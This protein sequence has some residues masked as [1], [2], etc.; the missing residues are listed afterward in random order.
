MGMF[1]PDKEHK[2]RMV[3]EVDGPL[4]QEDY[5]QYKNEMKQLA[6]KH[7]AKVVGGEH[8]RKHVAKKA[9]ASKTGRSRAK[10]NG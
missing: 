7:H 8:I 1:P 6:R 3:I 9:T 4:S 5:D 2:H 10:R